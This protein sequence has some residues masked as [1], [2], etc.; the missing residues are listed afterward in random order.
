MKNQSIRVI[1]LLCLCLGMAHAASSHAAAAKRKLAA[2]SRPS[3]LLIVADDMGQTDLGIYGSEIRTPN[4]DQLASRG[5]MLT[6]YYA[7]PLCAPTRAMLLSGTDNHRAGE[8]LMDQT[9]E[10]AD[11]YEGHLNDRV[12]T[13]AS[14][15]KKVGYHTYMAGKWHLGYRD[16]QSAASRGFD[17]SFTLLAGGAAHYGMVGL[18]GAS[19]QYRDDGKLVDSLPADFYS[20]TYY[21]DKMLG[22]M[23]QSAGDGKPF[24]A[25]LAYTAPHWPMQAPEADIQRQRG[26]YDAG[27]E[28]LRQNRFAAWKARGFAPRDAQL[29]D[30]PPGYTPWSELNSGQQAKSARAM[31]VYAAMVERMDT[32]VGR[33]LA[34]L[35]QSGQLDNTLILFQSDNGAEGGFDRGATANDDVALDD[36]GRPGSWVYVGKG[37][38]EAQGAPYFL[39]KFYTGEGGIHVPAFAYGPALGVPSGKRNDSLLIT[40]DVAPTLLEFAG[41]DAGVPKEQPDALPITGRSFAAILTGETFTRRR[42]ETDTVGWE[43]SGHAAIRRGDFKLLWVGGNNP[44]TAGVGPARPSPAA[45]N[46]VPAGSTPARASAPARPALNREKMAEGGPAGEPVGKGG[47]WKLYNLRQD[48]AELHDLSAQNPQLKSQLLDEW[49]R[50]AR[51]SGVIVKSGVDNAQR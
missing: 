1:S 30:L 22:Y 10:G 50:Y 42:G 51:E 35:R 44:P 41:A 24:F 47:P 31:E 14:R 7:S 33:V 45:R 40:P 27:Y 29:P 4:L 25:Y 48:P 19:A 43:H 38:A 16:E 12:A 6:S 36:I 37:W 23:K 32:E 46:P 11:G 17:R 28:V 13:L 18:R 39:Q 5:L 9:V 49:A 26:R 3:I 21:T 15:L 34:Y 2:G 8:G 20:T